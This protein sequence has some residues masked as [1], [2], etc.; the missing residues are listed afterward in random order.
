[1]VDEDRAK[2]AAKN[3]GGKLK[4]GL[5]KAVGDEKLQREGQSDKARGKVQNVVG[6]VK[7]KL[8]DKP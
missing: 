5:G 2:G 4:E 3:T 1:M 8:R 6:G 7:D